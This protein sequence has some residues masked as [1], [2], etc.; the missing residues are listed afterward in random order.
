LCYNKRLVDIT[1]Y[2]ADVIDIYSKDV[3][4]MI[5]HGYS[6]WEDMVPAYVDTII[7]DNKLFD[8]DPDTKQDPNYIPPTSHLKEKRVNPM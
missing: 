5:K 2:N 1:D 7:K 3:L 4:D 6:G 8:Y